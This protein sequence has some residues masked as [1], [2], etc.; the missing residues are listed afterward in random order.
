MPHRQH[1][2]TSTTLASAR[3]QAS[4]NTGR[5]IRLARRRADRHHH[6]SHTWQTHQA[7][8][9]RRQRSITKYLRD[10]IFASV[11]IQQAKRNSHNTIWGD[12]ATRKHTYNAIRRFQQQDRHHPRFRRDTG[13]TTGLTLLPDRNARSPANENRPE[14]PGFRSADRY[15]SI[16][17]CAIPGPSQGSN[18]P[19]S[20]LRLLL[21]RG[22]GSLRHAP[23]RMGALRPHRQRTRMHQR[24]QTSLPRRTNIPERRHVNR[25]ACN[26]QTMQARR[27]IRKPTLPTILQPEPLQA[28]PRP[29]G[30]SSSQSLL[31]RHCS[32]A[33][34]H[35]DGERMPLAENPRIRAN[36]E[37]AA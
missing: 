29:Q 12:C 14:R 37:N 9:T 18:P 11:C 16:P 25:P 2:A 26:A 13:H 3:S 23:S 24:V 8:S 17:N 20:R 35:H 15:Q 34:T 22:R 32:S 36:H 28:S 33:A 7:H 1:E 21:R 4:E 31:P 30:H 5:T 19:H 27:H 6:A 10:T